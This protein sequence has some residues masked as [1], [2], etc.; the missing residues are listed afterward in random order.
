MDDASLLLPSKRQVSGFPMEVSVAFAADH[1]RHLEHQELL[2]QAS[3]DEAICPAPP[4]T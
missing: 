4:P 1:L 3:S 2:P